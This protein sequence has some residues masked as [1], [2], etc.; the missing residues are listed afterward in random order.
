M[1]ITSEVLIM[2]TM[3]ILCKC[4]TVQSGRSVMMFQR[5]VQFRRATLKMDTA[6]SPKCWCTC[7]RL[8]SISKIYGL[9]CEE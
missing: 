2:V 5:N 7:A 6:C 3:K 4:D 9:K 8:H 1:K